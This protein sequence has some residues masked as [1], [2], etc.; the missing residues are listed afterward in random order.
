MKI[1][2]PRSRDRPGARGERENSVLP[3]ASLRR[4]DRGRRP[5]GGDGEGRKPEGGGESGIPYLLMMPVTSWK[6]KR[7]TE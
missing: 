5:P 1:R 7:E 4:P 3:G 6:G 2:F